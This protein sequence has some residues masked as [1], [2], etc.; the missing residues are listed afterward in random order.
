MNEKIEDILELPVTYKLGILFGTV[1]FIGAGYWYFFYSSNAEKIAELEKKINGPTGLTYQISKQEAIAANLDTFEAEVE[2]LD[3]ELRKA[4]AEL[5]DKKEVGILLEKISDK[6]HD[7]GLEVR[8]FRPK[9][10]E[11]RDFYAEVPV[12]IEVVGTFHQVATF[13]D[14]VGRLERIVNLGELEMKDPVI[15]DEKVTVTTQVQ[16]TAFRFLD[17]S[18]RPKTDGEG[19]KKRRRRRKAPKV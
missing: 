14:E 15:S 2:K 18:E 13:F 10:T 19:S 11:K 17:E 12:S 9:A 3:I 7:T 8:L 5:P 4:L 16:A 1:L 6:A